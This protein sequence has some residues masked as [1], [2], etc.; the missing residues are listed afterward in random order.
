MKKL[1]R[2]DPLS[3][4]FTII[5]GLGFLTMFFTVG[6]TTERSV[7][8]LLDAIIANLLYLIFITLGFGLGKA[9]S[10]IK[11]DTKKD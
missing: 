10:E 11:E 8:T 6:E 1:F 4:L 3:F 5:F 7:L 9:H 2:R